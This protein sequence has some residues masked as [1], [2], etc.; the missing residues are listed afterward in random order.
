ME[1]RFNGAGILLLLLTISC[2]AFAGEAPQTDQNSEALEMIAKRM[3]SL[4]Q[5]L[6][7]IPDPPAFDQQI[8]LPGAFIAVPKPSESNK[9][10]E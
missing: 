7:G 9:E 2:A 4:T 8:Q 3:Q 10:N 1:R 6:G 5:S